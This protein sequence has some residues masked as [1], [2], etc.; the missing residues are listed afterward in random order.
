MIRQM[1]CPLCDLDTFPE[2]WEGC[3]AS[4]PSPINPGQYVVCT[5]PKGHEGPHAACG[6][7]DHQHPIIEW[8]TD[9]DV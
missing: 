9:K 3:D 7:Y 6:V 8:E 1:D 4:A 5:R 2:G